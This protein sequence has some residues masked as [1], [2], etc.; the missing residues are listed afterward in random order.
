MKYKVNE[1]FYS[2]QAEGRNAGR[3]AV[4]VRF[5][6]CN[7]RCPFC[8]TDHEPY[9]EMTGQEIDSEIQRLAPDKRTL[10]IFTGGEPLMQ[11]NDGEELAKGYPRAIE[12]NGMLSLPSW[13]SAND[14]LTI[15]PKTKLS[16]EQLARAKEIKVLYGLFSDH[17]LK[18]I[19]SNVDSVLYIQPIENK[20]TFDVAPVIEFIQKN[21]AW[22]LSV[23]W[24]KLTGVR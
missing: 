11:L 20:G 4:F 18:A 22:K 21:P 6:G 3:S 13:W 23:Q 7:L 9:K 17:W 16:M 1:I 5:A 10:V 12:S 14:W 2:V 15:S 8:D 24:H 19:E